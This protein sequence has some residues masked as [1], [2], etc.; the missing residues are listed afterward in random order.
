M[1]VLRSIFLVAYGSLLEGANCRDFW[2]CLESINE[3][4]PCKADV[5]YVFRLERT[6]CTV[7]V[8]VHG[9]CRRYNVR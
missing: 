1:S 8:R 5:G 4:T 2:L 7:K 3:Q 6:T 9:Q